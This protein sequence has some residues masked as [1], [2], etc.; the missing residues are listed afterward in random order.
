MRE[1][2]VLI[3][4]VSARAL[5][6]AARRD[7]YAPLAADLFG[8]NDLRA[9]ACAHERLPGGLHRG[10]RGPALLAALARLAEGRA[11]IGLVCGS[12]FESR[13]ALLGR[14][15][16]RHEL[17]GN[18]AAT[19]RA[20]KDPLK[21]A[22]LCRRLGIPHPEIRFDAAPD[23]DWLSKRI[24]GAGGA[25]IRPV[26]AGRRPGRGRYLQRRVGGAPVS[27]LFLAD[28]SAC[29]VLGFTEQWSSP[30][31]R[32]R[33]RYGGAARPAVL[34]PPVAQALTGAV[35]R[36]AAGARLVG[37][38]SAD[39][40]VDDGEFHLVEINPRPGATFD[41][42][43]GPG[44]FAAHLAACAGKLDHTLPLPGG[45]AAAAIAYARAPLTIPPGFAWPEWA[46]DRQPAGS[47]VA[48]HEPLCTVRAEAAT[49]AAARAL[50][51][52][53]IETIL[54]MAEGAR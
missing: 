26:R 38:N 37:A 44:L 36:L 24:G 51:M 39:F 5:A 15:A 53:R 1:K 46:A 30:R 31:P 22:G 41:L 2:F 12:G 29:R 42:F 14:L 6:Q 17:L 28:G 11:P 54:A 19:V 48:A 52:E 34:A 40:L 45:G 47:P 18:D 16:R 13:P 35:A 20:V 10:I 7:G 4:A 8:D 33:Y 23:G 32:R 43:S 25:H 3:A 9:A 21:L 50:V 27:V 49:A